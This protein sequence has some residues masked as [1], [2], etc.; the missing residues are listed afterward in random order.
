MPP[1]KDRLGELLRENDFL[2]GVICRDVTLTDIELMAQEGYHIV[3]IDLEHSLQSME[4]AIQ[5]GRSVT[6]LGMVPLVRIRELSRTNVQPLVDGGVSVIAL[7]DVRSADQAAEL[8]HLS[9]YPPL[10][11]RGLSSTSAGFGFKLDG[12]PKEI[13]HRVNE[14]THLMVLFESDEGYE[15]LDNIL[16]VEGIDMVGVGPMD[17]STSLGISGAEAKRNLTPKI[18]RA[19]ANAGSAGKITVM[20]GGSL[21]QVAF[22]RDLGTRVFF[23][24]VDIAMRRKILVESIKGL[25]RAL[26]A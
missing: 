17:W 11:Q 2:Y 8:V 22:Y 9:K 10:G 19:F 12:D 15:D 4:E 3:W 18:E 20:G 7:P 26:E 24:G 21:E 16:G 14:A 25:Q 5:L 1:M 23:V 6:H 13:L